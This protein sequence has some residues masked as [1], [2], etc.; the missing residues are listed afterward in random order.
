MFDASNRK[1]IRRAEK[2]A[3]QAELARIEFLRSA[4]SSIGGRS[5]FHNILCVCHLFSDPFTGDALREAF[6]KGER[7]IGLQLFSDI[8]SHCPDQYLLMMKESNARDS[9]FSTERT[10]GQDSDG[11]DS[12]P[13]L[14]LD[15]YGDNT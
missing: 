7:N 6:L 12:E 3:R 2:A 4:L 14:E 5:F 13:E 8:V 9:A 1:D 10:G 15:P 11:G